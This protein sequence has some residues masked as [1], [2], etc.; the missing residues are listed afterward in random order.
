MLAHPPLHIARERGTSMIEVL[1][2]MVILAFGLLG[3][4]G[5]QSKL[6]LSMAESFQRAQAVVLVNDLS[7]RINANR[8]QAASYV[9]ASTLGT[10]DAQPEDCSGLASGAT[11]D[12]CE[13]SNTLKGA[14]EKKSS[15]NTGAMTDARG[16]VTQVQAPDTTT[17][18]PGVY[19]V[20]VAWQGLHKTKAPDALCGK[21]QYGDD[22]Y[23]RAISV[24]VAVGL[25]TCSP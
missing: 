10:G 1:V 12:L 7:E 14:S 23:R 8:A 17:C 18:T 6:H 19:L 25:P 24:R 13:W 3:L 20:T 9:S 4:A 15:V 2:T 16:C 21:D 22:A 5:M 11:R